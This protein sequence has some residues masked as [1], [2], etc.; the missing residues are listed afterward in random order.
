[1]KY[2]MNRNKN[3]ITLDTE[4]GCITGDTYQMKDV[5]KEE[6]PGAAWNKDAKAWVVSKMA[7][8]IE[9][10]RSY[11]TRCYRLAEVKTAEAPATVRDAVISRIN[12]ICPRC[13]TYCYGD[14][15]FR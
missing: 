7:E 6:F 3:T 10:Y 4:T 5:I 11:L 12:G 8:R 1:M 9:E 15:S 2:T 13:H 14:C